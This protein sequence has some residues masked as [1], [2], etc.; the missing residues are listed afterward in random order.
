MKKIKKYWK[1]TAQIS[2]HSTMSVEYDHEPTEKD[3]EIFFSNEKVHGEIKI[4][5][6]CSVYYA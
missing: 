6:F 5:C 1:L 3:I 4:E 2:R